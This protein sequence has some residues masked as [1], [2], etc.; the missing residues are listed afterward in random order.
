[1]LVQKVTRIAVI[2][3]SNQEVHAHLKLLDYLDLQSLESNG[4]L[5]SCLKLDNV[6]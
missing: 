3:Y 2:K 5:N 6:D 1:M 4:K